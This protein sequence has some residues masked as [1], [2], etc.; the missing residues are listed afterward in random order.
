[1]FAVPAWQGSISQADKQ[2][3]ERVQKSACHI[4]LG[5]NY[6][7]YKTALTE[8]GLE[9]LEARRIRLCLKFALKAE[10]H[11]KLKKNGSNL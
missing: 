8:L 6:S 3:I 7:G 10:S 5:K 2:V 11:P 1:M 9:S 4:I